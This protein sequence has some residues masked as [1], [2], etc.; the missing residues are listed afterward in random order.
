MV[1][2]DQTWRKWYYDYKHFYDI[3]FLKFAEKWDKIKFVYGI[4]LGRN[5]WEYNKSDEAIAK[6]LLKDFKSISVREKGAI[7]LIK[8][9]LGITPYFVLDPTLI[10]D[11]QYYLNLIKNY[12]P[13][14]HINDSYIFIYIV[15]DLM[16][17]HSFIK[18]INSIYK[19][20]I[21]WVKDNILDFIYGIYYSKAII[22]DSFHDTVFSI[23]FNKPFIAFLYEYTGKERFISLKEIFDIGDRLY[24]INSKP[25]ISLLEKPLHINMKKFHSLKKKV[26]IF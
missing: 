21:Y 3:A 18:E 8:E 17:I 26:L 10:I 14:I 6:Y 23:I 15:A 7:N 16:K 1:N 19:Y 9:H 11:K 20:K 2:S 4:S 24:D 12:K 5:V 25:K 13:K 22:T